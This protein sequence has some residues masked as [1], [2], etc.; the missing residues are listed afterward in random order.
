L[1]RCTRW[2]L[3]L[4]LLP[5][6]IA[7]PYFLVLFLF[8]LTL[9]AKPCFY[10][11]VLLTTL[12]ISSCYWQPFPIDNPLSVPWSE[13]ITTFAEALNATLAANYTKQL[14]SKMRVLDRCWCDFSSGKF[15][16]PFNISGWEYASVQRMKKDLERAEGL[17][18]QLPIQTANATGKTLNIS[19]VTGSPLPY[20]TVGSDAWFRYQWQ[21]WFN[22]PNSTEAFWANRT[23][24]HITTEAGSADLTNITSATTISNSS[25]LPMESVP[26][27]STPFNWLRTEYD[28]QPYGLGMVIDLRWS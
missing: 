4:L 25:Q 20:T 5:L 24:Q 10:C 15:F 9:H 2:Y 11:I 13:N 17:A 26:T 27:S 21:K 1:Y 6:P 16:E 7:P 28:L 19:T 18:T 23:S 8:S 12:L 14:P 22:R 3:P